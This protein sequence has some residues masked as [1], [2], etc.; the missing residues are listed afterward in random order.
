MRPTVQ[1]G[2]AW[3][4]QRGVSRAPNRT[5]RQKRGTPQAY[6][7]SS[8]LQR[9]VEQSPDRHGAERTC[10]ALGP[11]GAL[12]AAPRR[13]ASREAFAAAFSDGRAGGVRLPRQRQL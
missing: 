11:R 5:A 4:L 2:V 6:R 3:G 10:P 7:K 1:R 9:V 12:Q 8:P 13:L